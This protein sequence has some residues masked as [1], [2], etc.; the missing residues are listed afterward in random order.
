MLTAPG[1]CCTNL[2]SMPVPESSPAHMVET[3]CITHAW[4]CSCVVR[5]ANGT[6]VTAAV[7]RPAAPRNDTAAVPDDSLDASNAGTP[8]VVFTICTMRTLAVEMEAEVL[9]P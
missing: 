3:S 2:C 1:A 5:P 8:H 6:A 7:G 4:M 9:P